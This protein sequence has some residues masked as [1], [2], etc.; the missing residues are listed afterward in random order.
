MTLSEE[1]RQIT[2]STIR[3]LKYEIKQ[4]LV[5]SALEGYEVN[6]TT[7]GVKIPEWALSQIG[8][9][10]LEEKFQVSNHPNGYWVS[11]K[12]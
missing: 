6:L 4:K 5:E 2:E 7:K 12:P 3:I 8:A 10:L 11:W 1:C 9:W